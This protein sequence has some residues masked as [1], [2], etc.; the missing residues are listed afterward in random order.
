M[1][2]LWDPLAFIKSVE[3]STI[4]AYITQ[5][6]VQHL[7]QFLMALRLEFEGLY[8]TILHRTPVPFVD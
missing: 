2:E 4:Q 7:D 8:G 1:S 3:L 6:E 5:R